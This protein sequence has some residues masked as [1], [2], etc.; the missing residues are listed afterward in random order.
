MGE[1]FRP[2]RRKLAVVTLLFACVFMAGWVFSLTRYVNAQIHFCGNEQVFAAANGHLYL[3][4]LSS[5]LRNWIWCDYVTGPVREFPA[6]IW[7]GLQIKWK[8]ST[9]FFV[10]VLCD[11]PGTKSND[12]RLLDIPFWVIV[13]P[14]VLTTM[15]LLFSKRPAVAKAESS[16][17][18][19]FAVSQSNSVVEVD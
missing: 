2:L 9:S 14:L 13:P 15:W 17:D 7:D 11:E 6:D 3:A 1:Y 4:H 16:V 5:T 10:Y 19:V 8:F 18:E 12:I